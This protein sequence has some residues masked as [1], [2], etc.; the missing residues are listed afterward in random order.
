MPTSQRALALL[1]AI[2]PLTA[3]SP[4]PP[5]APVALTRPLG[6]VFVD[7]P[8]D[9]LVWAR[10]DDWKAS[11]GAHGCSFVPFLGSLAPRN[12]PVT[13]Q[14]TD[15]RCGEVAL[16]LDLA[17]APRAH[18]KTRISIDRGALTEVYELTPRGIEQKFVFAE[19]RG[20]GACSVSMHVTTELA[21]TQDADGSLRFT[22]ELGGVQIGKATAVDA[23]GA[24]APATTTFANGTLVYTVPAEFVARATFP[25]TIDPYFLVTSLVLP[26]NG[27]DNMNPD[28]AYVSTLGGSYAAVFEEVFSA[29]DHDVGIRGYG[30]GGALLLADYVDYTTTSWRKPR[31]ASHVAASQFLCVAERSVDIG[32]RLVDLA[33]PQTIPTFVFGSQFT[34]YQTLLGTAS[35]PDVG[36]DPSPTASLPGKYCVAWQIN[37]SVVWRLV[38]TDGVLGTANGVGVPPFAAQQNPS[39]SKCCSPE[40]PVQQWILVWEQPAGATDRDIHGALLSPNGTAV[41]SDFLI[42]GSSFSDTRPH[43][44]SKTDFVSGVDRWMVVWQRAIPGSPIAVAHD[45]IYGA[46]FQDTTNLTGET[47][48]TQLLNRPNFANQVHPCVDTDGVRFAVGFSEKASA[49]GN[50]WEPYLAT[51]HLAP[52]AQ[53]AV[54]SYPELLNAYVEVDD[55]LEI[56]AEHSGGTYTT[57][58]VA[59]WT[60]SGAAGSSSLAAFY[61]GHSNVPPSS[62]YDHVVAG[63]GAMQLVEN[64]LPALGETMYL[65]LVNAQGIPLFMIGQAAPPV[66]LCG[67]CEIGID[68]GTL[69]LLGQ[70]S[71]AYTVPPDVSLIGAQ[72]AVQ[73][74]DVFAP[75]GCPL[76]LLGFEFTLT[77]EI[78]I[79]FL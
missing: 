19:R 31:I 8:G 46:V 47:N 54:T 49:F 72:V 75:G 79:T 68:A 12:F 23:R 21:A 3:Q 56:T 5:A 38:G 64:G 70:A 15:A 4:E 40:T 67:G 44:S 17:N 32:G 7:Q 52:N 53:L 78:V 66:A 22:N 14:L 10:G 63:C 71:I 36:G 41:A 45:D 77:D 69:S 37:N 76:S 59:T 62:Y 2:L 55:N 30:H 27:L 6:R 34:V 58:Y 11:F 57:Q 13:V 74:I 51:V 42:S 24:S 73:G 61:R 9:G 28:V 50:D 20:A 29:A 1:G 60:A 18:E 65:D 39:L 25:L 33:T 43:V 48:L 16:P 26:P 35:V